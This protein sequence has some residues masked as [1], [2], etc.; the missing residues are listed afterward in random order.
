MFALVN[1]VGCCHC[2]QA[3][4][5]HVNSIILSANEVISSTMG[6][7][8]G[9]VTITQCSFSSPPGDF[10]ACITSSEHKIL[11]MFVKLCI[12]PGICFA[13]VPLG[14]AVYSSL[15]VGL[16]YR[17]ESNCGWEAIRWC[18]CNL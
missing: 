3:A 13:V 2:M 14:I 17:T 12:I 16:C 15:Y 10:D 9:C 18:V 1:V 11:R 4:L 5:N 6:Y 8:K 7:D